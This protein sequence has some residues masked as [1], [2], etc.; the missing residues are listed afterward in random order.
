M[1]ADP[2]QTI[3]QEGIG[4]LIEMGITKGRSA[5]A[6][7]AKKKATAAKAKPK[8]KPAKKAKKDRK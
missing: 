6:V 4:Q 5:K 3:D 2:F 8:A 7:P 1:P